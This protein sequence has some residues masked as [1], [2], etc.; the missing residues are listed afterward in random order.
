MVLAE[1]QGLRVMA[2]GD[3]E[4][5]AQRPLLRMI[6]AA[7]V[8]TMAPVDVVVVAHHGSARQEPRLY[9]ALQPRVALIGVGAGNDYGHPAASALALLRRVGAVTL[10]TDQ[11]GLVAVSGPSARLR[12]STA[13]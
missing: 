12:V 8:G 13:K 4:P 9:Q 11:Q 10:R 3:V 5:E 7:S 1:V 2:L 6:R